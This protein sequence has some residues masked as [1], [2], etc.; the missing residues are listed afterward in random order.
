MVPD[1]PDLLHPLKIYLL[2]TSAWLSALCFKKSERFMSKY[3]DPILRVSKC[4]KQSVHFLHPTRLLRACHRKR[5]R[6]SEIGVAELLSMQGQRD[7]ASVYRLRP[8]LTLVP[9]FGVAEFGGSG[10][11]PVRRGSRRMNRE[12]REREDQRERER[13][14]V[15]IS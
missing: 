11:G 9:N 2:P 3:L 5:A 15:G 7:L 4:W 10:R 6:R 1:C 14:I 13:V 12:E 8:I